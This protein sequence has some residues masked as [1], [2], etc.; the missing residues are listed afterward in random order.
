MC[1]N[2]GVSF[3]HCLISY[4][5]LLTGLEKIEVNKP[6]I[7]LD[8]QNNWVVVAE[9][10]VSILK[11]NNYPE[12]YET[13]KKFTRNNNN[14]TKENISAFIDSLYITPD[15]ELELRQITPFNYTGIVY[16]ST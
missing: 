10:I 6:K 12:P 8:L 9:G 2:I 14:I 1:R 4:S 16:S 15:V 13:L 5:S 3:G 7:E 11:K